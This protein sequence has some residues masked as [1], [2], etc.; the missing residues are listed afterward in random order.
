MNKNVK[1]I[2]TET[3]NLFPTTNEPL[4]KISKAKIEDKE[5]IFIKSIYS[6]G[7]RMNVIIHKDNLK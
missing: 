6:T 7:S 2:W 3:I 1:V 5:Y 4:Y